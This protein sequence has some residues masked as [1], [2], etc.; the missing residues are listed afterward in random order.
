VA[1]AQSAA[2]HLAHHGEGFREQ[3]VQGLST[4]EALPELIG[5]GP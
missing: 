1:L 4:G 2:G 5:L 3:V